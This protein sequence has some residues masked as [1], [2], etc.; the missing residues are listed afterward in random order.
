VETPERLEDLLQRAGRLLDEA[1]TVIRELEI[2]P[3][4]NIRRIGEALGTISD[5]RLTIYQAHPA[6]R[7]DFLREPARSS[8]EQGDLPPELFRVHALQIVD[9]ITGYLADA[10]W[11]GRSGCAPVT[12]ET[13]WQGWPRAPG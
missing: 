4:Q 7:P 13:R 5:I 9:W 11:Y 3:D 6:R 10:R 8:S 1:A 12:T 2:A